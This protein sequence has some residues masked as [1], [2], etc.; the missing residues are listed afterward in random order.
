MQA[1][2]LDNPFAKVPKS[3]IVDYFCAASDIKSALL[4]RQSLI[5]VDIGRLLGELAI[6]FRIHDYDASIL[7][8]INKDMGLME[9]ADMQIGHGIEFEY[10][11]LYRSSRLPGGGKS[12][13]ELHR[14]LVADVEDILESNKNAIGAAGYF[15]EDPSSLKEQRLS[16]LFPLQN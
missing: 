6:R 16:Y 5:L 14:F 1:A 3:S 7:A 15:M 4:L 2:D 11:Q 9:A 8:P 10:L 13:F 12:F